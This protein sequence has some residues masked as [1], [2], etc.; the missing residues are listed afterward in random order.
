M[1]VKRSQHHHSISLG[2]LQGVSGRISPTPPH[3]AASN[4][5]VLQAPVVQHIRAAR[6]SAGLGVGGGQWS[7]AAA[8]AGLGNGATRN[9]PHPLARLAVPSAT[10]LHADDGGSADAASTR[11]V[12]ASRSG[13][14][15]PPWRFACRRTAG[16]EHGALPA[17]TKAAM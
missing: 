17:A 6:G 5:A 11:A 4:P 3:G 9:E 15:P 1:Y 7:A 14:A 13:L 10:E 8:A 16:P 2:T 12:E